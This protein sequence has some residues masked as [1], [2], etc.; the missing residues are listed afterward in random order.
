MCAYALDAWMTLALVIYSAKPRENIVKNN[1]YEIQRLPW[2]LD[3]T[4]T[5]NQHRLKMDQQSRVMNK[6][7]EG[8]RGFACLT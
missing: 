5:N 4:A 7:N 1:A 6:R 8:E 3:V 2:A